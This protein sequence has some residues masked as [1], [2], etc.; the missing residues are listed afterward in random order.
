MC[1]LYALVVM[2]FLALAAC[3]GGGGGTSESADVIV[4]MKEWSVTPTKTTIPAGN[5]RILVRNVGSTAHDFVIIRTDLPEDKLPQ[6]GG[7]VKEDGKV[8]SAGELN[9]GQRATV[10]ANLTPGKYVWICN[11]AGHYPVGMHVSVTVQ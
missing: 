11:V 7:K 8:A 5:I 2:A 1:R 10:T 4:D 6:D 9:P 3:G